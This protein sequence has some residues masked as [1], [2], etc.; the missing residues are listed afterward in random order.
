MVCLPPGTKQQVNTA[1]E[2]IREHFPE[3]QYPDITLQ[4][5]SSQHQN[6]PVVQPTLNALSMQV[7]T[8]V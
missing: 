5:V 4:Q 2:M 7:C 8:V 1:L 3:S 6:M